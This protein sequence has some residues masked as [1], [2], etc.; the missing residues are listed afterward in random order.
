MKLK[1][2]QKMKLKFRQKMCGITQ[3]ALT[4]DFYFM[5]AIISCIDN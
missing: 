3:V 1:F 2:R 4:I 5:Y